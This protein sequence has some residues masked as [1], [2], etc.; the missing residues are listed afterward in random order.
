[1]KNERFVYPKINPPITKWFFDFLTNIYTTVEVIG[2]ENIPNSGSYLV[3]SNHLSNADFVIIARIFKDT[4][5]IGAKVIANPCFRLI[6]RFG[7]NL[8][9]LEKRE[10]ASRKEKLESAKAVSGYV[11][12]ELKKGE[13]TFLVFPE[14]TRSRTGALIKA[15]KRTFGLAVSSGVPILPVTLIGTDKALPIVDNPKTLYQKTIGRLPKRTKT[16]KVVIG[17]PKLF[18]IYADL[19]QCEKVVM[20]AIADSL[21]PEKRGYY[22]EMMDSKGV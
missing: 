15:Q 11:I 6:L 3:A 13:K 22:K 17:K 7:Y 4:W 21:P 5:P 9:Y 2:E 18:S 14:A 1:M 16:I 20:S 10:S 19:N 12:E 8:I